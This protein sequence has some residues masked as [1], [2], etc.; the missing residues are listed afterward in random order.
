MSYIDKNKAWTEW[1]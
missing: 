1:Q